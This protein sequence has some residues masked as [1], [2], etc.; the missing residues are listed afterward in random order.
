MTRVTN[1]AVVRN[2]YFLDHLHEYIKTDAPKQVNISNAQRKPLDE[3]ATAKKWS[4]MNAAMLKLANMALLN[5]AMREMGLEPPAR[6][7]PKKGVPASMMPA[8][9]RLVQEYASAADDDGR[10]AAPLKMDKLG[11]VIV[12]HDVIIAGLKASGLY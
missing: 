6:V 10:K 1:R 11:G 7:L 8:M 12:K 3:A 2:R 4:S 5:A 9:T